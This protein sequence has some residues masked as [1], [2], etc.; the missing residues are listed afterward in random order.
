MGHV[1]DSDAIGKSVQ[2]SFHPERSGDLILVPKP[3]YFFWSSKTGPTHGSPHA[4]DTFVPLLVFGPGMKAG[5]HGDAV[6]PQ[7]T[8]AILATALGLP[9]PSRAEAAVP[10]GLFAK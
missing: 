6:T 2:K 4:Y 3:F 1:P 9:A 10:T 5:K 7:A 8:A